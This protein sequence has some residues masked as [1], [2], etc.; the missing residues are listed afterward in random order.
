MSACVVASAE[1][2]AAPGGVKEPKGLCDLDAAPRSRDNA[3]VRRL[4]AAAA[5]TALALAAALAGLWVTLPDPVTVAAK[6]P[7]TTAVIEQRRAEARAAGQSFS[8]RRTWVPLERISPRLVDAVLL[9]ED[10]RFYAHG[11]FDWREVEVAAQESLDS[12]RA[13]RGASTLTQ[14][15]AKNLWLGTDRTAWRKAKEAVLAVKLERALKKRRILALYLNV[16]EWDDGVFGAE[17]AARERFGT[18]AA[19]LSTAE[20]ALLA[21]MLPAPR[22]ADLAHPSRWL[23]RRSRHVLDLLREA[24]RIDDGEHA[25]ASAEL[26]RL[27]AGASGPDADPDDT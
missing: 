21:A 10:A 1:L 15:L 13:L 19:D 14:Q 9:S 16:A 5:L 23:A 25:R 6:N 2:S 8:V 20:A 3:P 27:L 26:E 18:T 11:A 12:G 4:L 24:H 22:R 7:R 17:A